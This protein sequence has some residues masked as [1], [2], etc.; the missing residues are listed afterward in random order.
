MRYFPGIVGLACMGLL[1]STVAQAVNV[2]FTGKLVE[3]PECTVNAGKDIAVNFD[4]I[5]VKKIDGA[6]YKKMEI[7]YTV[8]C[9]KDP[10]Y[11]QIKVMM[12]FM[13]VSWGDY[14]PLQ[15]SIPN[16]GLRITQGTGD[17]T[18]VSKTKLAIGDAA[19]PTKLYAI[20]ISRPGASLVAGDFSGG[21][22]LTV[23]Y[24]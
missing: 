20:P 7:P 10:G 13:E 8:S 12:D 16:L 15:S 1:T 19:N 22:T 4:T 11:G 24:E 9:G 2:Q 5:D 23:M 3:A 6:N 17:T 18:Y 14:K 21:A